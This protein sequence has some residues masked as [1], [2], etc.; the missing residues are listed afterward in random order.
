[1]VRVFVGH[2]TTVD[3]S[4]GTFEKVKRG[5]REG[6]PPT[7]LFLLHLKGGMVGPKESAKAAIGL[8]KP[9]KVIVACAS[10]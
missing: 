1:M 10:T 5:L 9:A 8:H 7:L 3:P 6:I 2:R 4:L